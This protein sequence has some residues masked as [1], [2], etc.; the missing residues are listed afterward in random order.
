MKTEMNSQER[1]R[2]ALAGKAPDR[3]PVQD[4]PWGATVERW[5]TEGLPPG[6]T[7]AEYFHYEMEKI[8]ADLSPRY[9]VNVLSEDDE[10]I[11]E[12]TPMGGIRRNHKD[13]ST[14]PEV[15]D[16]PIKKKD[17]WAP[18]RERLK[19]DF[20][21]VD[22]AS[23]L[24]IY[25]KAREE[26]KY[27]VFSAASG[28]DLLQYYIKSEQLLMMMAEDPDFVKEMVD[29]TSNLILDTVMRMHR[30]G[31]HFD[32]VW[33]YNDMGY[34][35]SSLF[36]PTMYRQIIAPS[37]KKR[38]DRLHEKGMQTILH[39]CGCVKGLVPSLIDAGFDCLQP[40]EVKAGMDLRELKPLYGNQ[41]ALFGGISVLLMGDPDDSKIEAEIRE[42]FK[43]AM[44]GGGYLYHSDH[45]IPKDVSFQKYKF[46]M[47]CVRKYGQY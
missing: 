39:S 41:I 25:S 22:W 42:K 6:K 32:G 8:G 33:I 26:G 10:F 44:P 16:C 35:N 43:V 28:Y 20:K 37:D 9:P 38:N 18:I 7:P 30:E 4:S 29:V 47:E 3:V 27:I 21:R 45:S 23:A 2:T 19:P 11:V 1:M 13:R 14:T 24:R 31:V 46:V 17:D 12:T 15:I 34:R 36:S 5:Y 40:L